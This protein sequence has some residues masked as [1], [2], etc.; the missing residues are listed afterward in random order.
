[1]ERSKTRLALLTLLISASMPSIAALDSATVKTVVNQQFAT[2]LSNHKTITEIESPTGNA[3]AS[4]KMAEWVKQQFTPLG[5]QVEFRTNEKGTHVIA[6]KKGTGDLRILLLGHTDTVQPVGSLQKQPYHYD[7]ASGLAKGPGAGD[8]K[9]SVAMLVA[10][11]N[12]LEQLKFTRYAEITFYFDAEEET[13][14]DTENQILEELAKTHDLALSVDSAPPGW[15]VNTERKWVVNYDI[16]VSGIT[17]HAGNS[18]QSGASATAE[19]ANQ[20]TR[21]M[22]LASP[23]PE[24]PSAYSTE[25]LQKRGIEDHGQ[26]IPPLT[27]NVGTISTS[28]TKVNAI[29]ADASAKLDIRGFKLEEQQRIEQ[30]IKEIAATPTVKGTAVT[31]KGPYNTMPA[32]EKTPEAAKL[33]DA[34]KQ[35][36]HQQ[37]GA[38][39]VE[40]AAGGVTIGN[41][42][43]RY[44][45]TI[46][47]L[48]VETSDQHNLDKE[49]GYLNTFEPRTV[50]MILLLDEV[51]DK[52]LIERQK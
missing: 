49:R 13:G 21:I 12:A 33:V 36:A 6:S 46:D 22:A 28:N 23:L 11:A 34:Y 17:G 30:K 10:F 5:Y 38:N 27:I 9:A 16:N 4:K 45:P 50:T 43:S 18:A 19:L 1:M 51:T 25:A 39:I 41:F 35:I 8:S 44:I 42:T 29:P 14:S 26:F 37:Y 2:Y 52:Q 7:P 24:D 3:A 48:G 47:G 15:G 32:M 31:V 40:W 20:I